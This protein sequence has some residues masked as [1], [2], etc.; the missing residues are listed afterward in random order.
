VPGTECSE[1]LRTDSIAVQRAYEP[2]KL[3]TEDECGLMANVPQDGTGVVVLHPGYIDY[4]VC[5]EGSQTARAWNF[6]TT[7]PLEVHALCSD[8]L[9]NW[10]K[11]HNIEMVNFRDA[12]FGTQ[13]YQN[14]LRLIG[15]DLCVR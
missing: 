12:L 6:L 2:L 10:V 8:E 3:W 14:H 4:Y 9:K 13:D 1:V 7:R 11:A 5:R 15:S